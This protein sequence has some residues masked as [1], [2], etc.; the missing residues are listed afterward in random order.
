MD[1]THNNSETFMLIMTFRK[2]VLKIKCS[3]CVQL[4]EKECFAELNIGGVTF[5]VHM[6]VHAGLHVKCTLLLSSSKLECC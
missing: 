3:F 4:L 2:S 5:D 1:I 6:A